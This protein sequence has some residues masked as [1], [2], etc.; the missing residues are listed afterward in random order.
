[1]TKAFVM[2]TDSGIEPA[3]RK[4]TTVYRCSKP[5]YGCAS[6]DT[7]HTGIAHISLTLDPT[8][9]YPFFTHRYDQV[10]E[11]KP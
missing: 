6:D 7:R 10:E 3:A 1:M 11:V 2:L 9:D 5:D 8:G 4:G